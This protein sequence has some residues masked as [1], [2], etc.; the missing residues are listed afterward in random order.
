M[1]D[2]LNIEVGET[3][4]A[5]QWNFMKFC[6]PINSWKHA[7]SYGWLLL[8]KGSDSIAIVGN[9]YGFC[10]YLLKQAPWLGVSP[11]VSVLVLW[12]FITQCFVLCNLLLNSLSFSSFWIVRYEGFRFAKRYFFMSVCFPSACNVSMLYKRTSNKGGSLY[13]LSA[14]SKFSQNRTTP[15][16]SSTDMTVSL[17]AH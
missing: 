8:H 9:P 7:V 13:I 1:A 14:H 4:W 16:T 11:D 2:V 3:F 17:S 10:V 12:K 5:I 6:I 15:D